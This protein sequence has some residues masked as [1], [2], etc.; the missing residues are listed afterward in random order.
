MYILYIIWVH[1]SND[2]LLYALFIELLYCIIVIGWFSLHDPHYIILCI[3]AGF[4][5]K[6]EYLKI[7]ILLLHLLDNLVMFRCSEM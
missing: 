4:S 7:F 1:L 3:F 6:N 2:Y 5:L